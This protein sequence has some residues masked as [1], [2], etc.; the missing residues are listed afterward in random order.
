MG[1]FI[2]TLIICALICG[3]YYIYVYLGK[4]SYQDT[5]TTNKTTVTKQVKFDQFK[6]PTSSKGYKV[7]FF[8]KDGNIKA[9]ARANSNSSLEKAI[10]ELLKG[11]TNSE[12]AQGIFSEIP[13]TTKLMWVKEDATKYIINLTRDFEFGGGTH[14]VQSR[15]DQLKGTINSLNIKKPV[16]LYLDGK[17]VEYMGGEGIYIEQPLN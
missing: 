13:Q 3:G 12:K 10:Q 9:I 17:L 8:T 15:L 14:S 1:I 6:K 11:P 5:L 4:A 2:R 7:Y 16:Y